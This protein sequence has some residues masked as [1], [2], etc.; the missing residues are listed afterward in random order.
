MKNGYYVLYR[1]LGILVN[2]YAYIILFIFIMGLFYGASSWIITIG[3]FISVCLVIY[4][5]L[6][7][8]F[9]TLVLMLKRPIRFSLKEWITVNAYISIT[10][11]SLLLLSIV[12]LLSNWGQFV[13]VAKQ[14]PE[15]TTKN[16]MTMTMAQYMAVF[17]FFL[18][19]S[20]MVVAHCIWTL[21]LVRR[22]RDFFQ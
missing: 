4:S 3:V 11:Y 22:F 9:G 17:E 6:S 2:M 21:R 10:V 16:G 12:L 20:L 5:T 13:T 15:L 14:H 19:I 7:G 1:L 8:R 18:A